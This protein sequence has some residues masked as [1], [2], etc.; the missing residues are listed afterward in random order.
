MFNMEE[1]TYQCRFCGLLTAFLSV[2]L[3]HPRALTTGWQLLRDRPY[4]LQ[5]IRRQETFKPQTA[6]K[7]LVQWITPLDCGQ[8]FLLMS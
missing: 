8:L 4:A 3:V 6:L 5:S 1:N 2:L 7:F